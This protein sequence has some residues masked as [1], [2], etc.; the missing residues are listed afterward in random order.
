MLEQSDFRVKMLLIYTLKILKNESDLFKEDQAP[1]MHRAKP[2]Y[3]LM[4]FK[5]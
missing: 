2:F 4:L 5:Q 3:L 1:G